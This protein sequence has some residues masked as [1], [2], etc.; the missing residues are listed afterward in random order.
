MEERGEGDTEDGVQAKLTED[1]EAD[2]GKL[3]REVTA[4]LDLE[5]VRDLSSLCYHY[6]FDAIV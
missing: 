3:R 1:V 4:T 5:K 6:S 2:K